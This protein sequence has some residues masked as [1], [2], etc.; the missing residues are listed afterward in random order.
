MRLL[1]LRGHRRRDQSQHLH[2]AVLG[3]EDDLISIMVDR[4][5]DESGLRVLLLGWYM[6]VRMLLVRIGCLLNVAAGTAAVH[7]GMCWHP[8]TH[9]TVRQSTR[10][11]SHQLRMGRR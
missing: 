11:S 8:M 10:C 9:R 3:D 5:H 6:A 2:I 4:W 1:L 7:K